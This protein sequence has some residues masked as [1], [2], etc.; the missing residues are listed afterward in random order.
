MLMIAS[1]MALLGMQFS[2][3]VFL[4]MGMMHVCVPTSI[5]GERE[6]EWWGKEEK[7]KAQ[8]KNISQ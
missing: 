1:K 3:F 7:E 4:V 5:G 8:K 2:L 6:S